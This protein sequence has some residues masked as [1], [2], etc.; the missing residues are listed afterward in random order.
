MLQA[1]KTFEQKG[2]RILHGIIDSIWVQP[3]QETKEMQKICQEISNQVGI[4]LE[5][6]NRYEWLAFCSRRESRA[7]ALTRY[8][9]KKKDGDYKVRGIELRQKSTPQHI[10]QKQKEMLKR[11]DKE[12][13][14][15]PVLQLL[16]KQLKELERGDVDPEKLLIKKTVTKEPDQYKQRN[17]NWSAL[18]RT[19]KQ[20]FNVEPGE[21]IRYVVTNNQ[22]E[23]RKR[24]KIHYE[25]INEY[26]KDFYKKRLIKAAKSILSP[27]NWNENRIHKYLEKTKETKLKTY[28]K[29]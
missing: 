15:E 29:T 6:E 19:E 28:Q 7:G 2:W 3:Q 20:S 16:K 4:D 10:K 17:L 11:F 9:G 21:E 24:I 1:K 22:K 12:K 13:A 23:G 25:E 18:K 5:Y 26:D 14:P 8:F 27:L